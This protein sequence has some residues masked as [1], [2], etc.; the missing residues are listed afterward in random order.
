MSV[1]LSKPVKTVDGRT[2]VIFGSDFSEPCP[3]GPSDGKY[4]FGGIRQAPKVAAAGGFGRVANVRVD[5]D[6][7]EG[8]GLDSPQ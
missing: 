1:D 5:I 7:E 3:D 2:V 4:F 6:V 8:R